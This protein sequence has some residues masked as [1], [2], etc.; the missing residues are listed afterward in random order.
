MPVK[1]LLLVV[2]A[3]VFGLDA[4]VVVTQTR[5]RLTPLGLFLVTVAFLV[6]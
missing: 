6:P 5:V 1:T 3:V 4:F 2:A